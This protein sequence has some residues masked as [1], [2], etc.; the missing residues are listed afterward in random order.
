M[1]T[2]L[3]KKFGFYPRHRE[4]RGISGSDHD[5]R[6]C[7]GRGKATIHSQTHLTLEWL[8]K[9]LKNPEDEAN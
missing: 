1:P 4:W 3:G 2:T 6:L 7:V 9:A 5:T 8:K